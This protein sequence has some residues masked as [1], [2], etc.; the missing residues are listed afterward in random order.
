MMFYFEYKGTTIFRNFRLTNLTKLH[1][2]IKSSLITIV[3]LDI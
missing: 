2:Q 1:C 3:T